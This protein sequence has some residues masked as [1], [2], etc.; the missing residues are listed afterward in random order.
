MLTAQ[1]IIES[2]WQYGID[3]P[4]TVNGGPLAANMDK[5]QL[6]LFSANGASSLEQTIEDHRRW[7]QSTPHSLSDVAYTLASRREHKAHRAYAVGSTAS[8]LEVSAAGKVASSPPPIVWVFTGQGA[9]WP[10]MGVE[11]IDSNPTFRSTIKKLD[12]FLQSLP[13]P[14]SW[15][16]EGTSKSIKAL[17]SP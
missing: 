3:T 13:I 7:L 6:F 8:S 14:P 15:T 12:R 1:V 5:A 2:P 16:V 11:L 10:Q 4:P 9:Q 17:G